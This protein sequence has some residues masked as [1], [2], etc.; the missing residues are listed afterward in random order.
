MKNGYNNIDLAE[1]IESYKAID[2]K[3]IITFLDDSTYTIP[4]TEDNENKL[5]SKMLEQAQE[6]S[7]SSALEKAKAG[8]KKALREAVVQTGFTISTLVTAS[9]TNL[10]GIRIITGV[11]AVFLAMTAI[12]ETLGYKIDNDEIKELEKYDIYL[13]IR[14]RLENITDPNLF[15]GVKK[16]KLPLNINTLDNYSLKDLQKIRDNLKRSE[17]YLF[18]FDKDKHE[19]TLTKKTSK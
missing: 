12:V 4:L 19:S 18:Y 9:I 7:E 5:L 15:N 13:S 10:K 8:R 14:E 17:K 11:L 2:N 6:R 1:L 3:I 16:A